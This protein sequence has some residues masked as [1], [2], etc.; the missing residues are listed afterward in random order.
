VLLLLVLA[1]GAAGAMFAA[2]DRGWLASRG[3][4]PGHRLLYGVCAGALVGLLLIPVLG[5]VAALVLFAVGLAAV[6]AVV[7]AAVLIAR[8][9]FGRGR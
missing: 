4:A 8:A 1:L 2:D 3:V 7:A 5:L 6:V 9:L